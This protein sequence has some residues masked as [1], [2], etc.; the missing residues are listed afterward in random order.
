H[1]LAHQWWG[2]QVIGADVQGSTMIVESLAQ[3]SALMAMEHEYGADHMKRFLAFE[4]DRYLQGRGGE[5]IDEMPLYL[6]ENQPYI[7]YRKGSLV[8]YAIKDYIGEDNMNLALADFL[9]KFAFGEAPY[10]TTRDLISSIRAF[11]PD[12]YQSVI[13]DMLER[14]VL[15]DLRVTDSQV[16]ELADGQYEVVIDVSARKFEASG[17]GEESEI[18]IRDWVDIGVFGAED[19]TTGVPEVLYLQKHLIEHNQQQI[20]VTV[21]ARPVTLGIDPLNKLIDRNP[22]DN[23]R[24]AR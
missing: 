17:G 23:V 11:T 18:T 2:H 9:D 4:L 15:F 14:I 21:S 7:H 22:S 1:E 10:P 19:P 24:S 6:V 5:A 3:Y 8:L 16:T 12:E 20:S 13:T